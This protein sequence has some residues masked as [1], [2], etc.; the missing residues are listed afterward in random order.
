M[1]FVQTQHHLWRDRYLAYAHPRL[2][3]FGRSGCLLLSPLDRGA[4]EVVAR[5]LAWTLRNPLRLFRP[6][7]FQSVMIIQPVDILEDGR[8]DMCDG[9]PDVTVWKGNLVWSCRLEEPK[10]Y[11]TFVRTVPKCML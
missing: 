10:Q 1:E 6:L 2:L 8:Q 9:C 7:H 11:G 3:R 5:Y 4:R